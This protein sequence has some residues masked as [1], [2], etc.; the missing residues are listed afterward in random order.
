MEKK[1]FPEKGEQTN[2]QKI[3]RSSLDEKESFY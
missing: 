2:K 1:K 3:Q